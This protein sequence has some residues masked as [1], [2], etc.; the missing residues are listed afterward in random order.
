MPTCEARLW[1][2]VCVVRRFGARPASRGFC[3]IR[4]RRNC[5]DF[6]MLGLERFSSVGNVSMLDPLI[7]RLARH[8]LPIC[9]ASGLLALGGCGTFTDPEVPNITSPNP[10]EAMYSE[11]DTLLDGKSYGD[12]AKKFEQVDRE[13]PYSPLARKSIVMSAYSYY[14]AGAYPEA[15][16]SAERYVTLHP[17]TKETA[18][19]YNI[20]ALSYYDQIKDPKRD[21]S[22]TR[23]ALQALQT[24]VRRYPDSRYAEKAKN[25]INITMDLLAASEM[26]VGRYYLKQRNY[27]ASI[28][29]FKV[30][31]TEYQT[32]AHV[33]EALMRLTEAYMALGITNEAQTAAAVL[34]HNFPDSKWYPHAYSL[35]EQGGLEPR[36]V[37]GSWITRTWG[38]IR[39]F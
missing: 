19:A 5:A 4:R 26:N 27:L 32:T 6:G 8:L 11:A 17:G 16:S 23:K 39:P 9:A 12:A 25:R 33:E 35:L 31:V 34:G 3:G 28:N 29:R 13:H 38:S 14:K 7:K 21:Q 10:P 18:L 20:I 24:V 30:V 1:R 22:R 37:Q 2:R 36:E 15:I